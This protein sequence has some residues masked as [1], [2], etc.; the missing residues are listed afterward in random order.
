MSNVSEYRATFARRIHIGQC[1]VIDGSPYHVI[2]RERGRVGEDRTV[3]VIQ[4]ACDGHCERR[5]R[6]S[7]MRYV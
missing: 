6:T 1:I 3:Y 5:S 4:R 7:L 2:R